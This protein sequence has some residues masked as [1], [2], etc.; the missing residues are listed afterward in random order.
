VF[1]QKSSLFARKRVDDLKLLA[2][3]GLESA[4]S[5]PGLQLLRSIAEDAGKKH[6]KDV[7][8]SATAAIVNVK[9][10]LTGTT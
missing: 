5:I 3:G 4:P 9:A 2:I 10:R 7:R 1:E 6:S 8:E